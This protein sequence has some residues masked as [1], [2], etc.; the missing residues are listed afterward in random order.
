MK[1]RGRVRLGAPPPPA[2]TPFEVFEHKYCSDV[3]GAL[4]DEKGLVVITPAVVEMVVSERASARRD[5]VASCRHA[6]RTL[7]SCL[8]RLADDM[9]EGGPIT[10][11]RNLCE[12]MLAVIG[13]PS[14]VVSH[15]ERQVRELERAVGEA[16][17]RL[18]AA[19]EDPVS[20][21]EFALEKP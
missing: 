16:N 11:A 12:S 19:G 8:N 2:K 21:P 7:G 4:A 15:L 18:L 13:S 1:T 5:V 10:L 20:Y 17:K 3:V 14:P 9:D 6:F